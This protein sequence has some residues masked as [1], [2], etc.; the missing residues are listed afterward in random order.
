MRAAMASLISV[1]TGANQPSLTASSRDSTQARSPSTSRQVARTSSAAPGCAYTCRSLASPPSS[2]HAVAQRRAVFVGVDPVVG[3]RRPPCRG[4]PSRRAPSRRAGSRRSA[5]RACP[6]ARAGWPTRARTPRTGGRSSRGRRGRRGR[7][8]GRPRR[9]RRR[10]SA[11]SAHERVG[12]AVVGAAQ[13]RPGQA[14]VPVGAGRHVDGGDPGGLRPFEDRRQ[15]LPADGVDVLRPAQ[16]VEQPPGA[17]HRDLVAEHPVR[18]GRQPGAE[19]AEA[20][21]R[22]GRGARG[23]RPRVEGELGEERRRRL[24]RAQQL[25]AEPVDDERQTRPISGRLGTFP[26][27]SSVGGARIEADRSARLDSP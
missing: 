19:R 26:A 9:A 27:S 15:R 24:V 1:P 22:G 7:A 5:R 20:G 8:C 21:H 10:S 14:A 16:A 6:R 23:Q 17:G 4:R 25:G 12:R 13:R 11:A 3:R 18:R 2:A